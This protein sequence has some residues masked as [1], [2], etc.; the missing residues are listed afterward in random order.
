MVYTVESAFNSFRENIV[1]L[2]PSD[3][4]KARS[5]RNYLF[6]QIRYLAQNNADFPRLA[7]NY[8]SFGSFARKTKIRPLDDIDVL[9]LLNGKGSTVSH[10]QGDI[11]NLQIDNNSAP[12]FP[13]C[14]S[15]SLLFKYVNSTKV[16]N[17]L[18]D[19]LSSIHNYRKAEIKKT[20]QAVTLNLSS[21]DWVFDIVPAVNIVDG[22]GNTLYYIIPDGRGKWIRTN[23]NIDSKNVTAINQQHGGNFLP[24]MRLLKYW[25]ARIY[26]PRLPSYYFEYL[27]IKVF[28][29]APKIVNF[30]RSIKY[31][32]DNCPLYI[33]SPCYDPKNLGANLDFSIDYST[34]QKV[35]EAMSQA[36]H[37]AEQSI[38]HQTKSSQSA[39][40]NSWRS[41]FGIEFPTYG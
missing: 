39:A 34:K 14:D 22:Y 7:G 16:L 12:L 35:I 19:R 4:S 23:P 27:A 11:Y 6:E 26:K 18:R 40:I 17:K 25:N 9:I 38:W 31:F 3:T 37:I 28:N 29:G 32:F 2:T 33:Q 10:Y 41:I 8:I 21:Y 15:S 1:D 20:M 24:L 36:S 30:S 13:F 5:S